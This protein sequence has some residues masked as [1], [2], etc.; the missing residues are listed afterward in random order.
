VPPIVVK[1]HVR[2]VD[3]DAGVEV[4]VVGAVLLLEMEFVL[5]LVV[6][7]IIIRLGLL[8]ISLRKSPESFMHWAL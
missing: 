6:T 5:V 7:T 1:L 8:Q 3:V 2:I 4:D